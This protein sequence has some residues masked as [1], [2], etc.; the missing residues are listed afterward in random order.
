MST[1]H[2]SPLRYPGGKTSLFDFLLKSLEKN[3]INYGTYVEGY[4]GGAGAALKLLMLEYVGDIYLNDKDPLLSTFW[5]AVLNHTE[6]LTRLIFNTEASI[7]NWTY[8]HNLLNNKN[9][10]RDISIP[11]LAFTCFYLNRC[12]RSGILAGGPIGGNDQTGTWKIDARY[13][14]LE[15]I[16]RIELIAL[17]KDRIHVSNKD[18]VTFLRN[19]ERLNYDKSKVLLYLDPPYVRQGKELY[20]HYF[21]KKDHIRLAQFLQK[22]TKYKWIV[23]YDDHEL[24]HEIYK[25][26]TKNIFEFNYYANRTKV[27]REL[28]IS[29]K[30]FI[31]PDIF[32]HYS[33]MRGIDQ[34]E[35]L[36]G[37]NS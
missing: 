3:N 14:K 25:E 26:V 11:E 34:D 31:L 7:D 17:Y 15:L 12:N 24:I 37:T 4:A 29:S 22:E 33:R 30:N 6:D 35:S 8:R 5:E 21:H 10:E 23:S 20:R 19:F 18:A 36:D 28:V 9:I 1:H 32:E 27:G 2:Y 13:N 16:K